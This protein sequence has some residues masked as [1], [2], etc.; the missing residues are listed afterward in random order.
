MIVQLS[1]LTH[2]QQDHLDHQAELRQG[3]HLHHACLAELLLDSK[4]RPHLVHLGHLAVQVLQR[5]RCHR[6]ARLVPRVVQRLH[7]KLHLQDHL[8]GLHPPSNLRLDLL[9]P[10]TE[11][12]PG[13]HLLS[14]L[15]DHRR[16]KARTSNRTSVSPRLYRLTISLDCIVGRS[17]MR[18]GELG[19]GT[20]KMISHKVTRTTSH[21][22][23]L[24][25]MDENPMT[26][27]R[28]HMTDPPLHKVTMH[29]AVNRLMPHRQLDRVTRRYNH[30]PPAMIPM[31][32][33]NK[34]PQ[35]RN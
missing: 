18:K 32:Q 16:P 29:T 20:N 27:P 13:N 9:P 2:H 14:L 5:S 21:H 17:Q 34:K 4:L 7:S 25:M 3:S 31:V 23:D 11:L 15:I 28:T 6:Q 1:S 30:K 26:S 35:Q 8:G 10:L 24:T 12:Q 22:D 19:T 33:V